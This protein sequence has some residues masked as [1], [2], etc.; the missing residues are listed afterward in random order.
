MRSPPHHPRMPEIP[1]DGDGPVFAAPWQAQAFAMVLK[2]YDGGHFAWSEWVDCLSGEIAA[3]KARGKPDLGGTYYNHWLAALEKLVAAKGWTSAV[4]LSDRKAAWAQ[5]DHD[6]GFG[7]PP[8][9]RP[10]PPDS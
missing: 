5:A 4:E 2:L 6:R 10:T 1:Q 8:V 9:L 3:A 7:E